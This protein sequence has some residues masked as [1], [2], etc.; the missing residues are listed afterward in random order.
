M[1]KSSVDQIRARFDQDVERFSNL[2]IGQTTTV[3]SPLMLEL[4]TQAAAANNPAAAHLLDVGCGAGNYTLKLLQS[5][6]DLEVTL[7]DLS[8][9]M[10]ARA[11]ERIHSVSSATIHAIQGDIRETTFPASQFD[12]ILAAAVLHHLRA[13][14]QWRAV[15]AKFHQV[16]K[17][18]GS[19]WIVDLVEQS[20]QAVQAIMWQR[21][22]DYL[23]DFK[24]PAFREQVFGYIEEEDSPRPLIFQ[25][26]LLRQVGFEQVEIL[27]KNNL[28]AAFG[29][30]K[31]SK[32]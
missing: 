18:G 25:L 15:F 20:T 1:P 6:P 7:L 22:G 31:A 9:P 16:L 23:V 32:A 11:V 24:G 2:E 30:I 19:L 17:P 26:D 21:Y 14:D 5:L 8:Q 12:V 28:F 3:D 4:V 10:L 27:H 29:A 13:A